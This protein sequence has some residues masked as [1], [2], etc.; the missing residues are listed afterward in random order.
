[1]LWVLAHGARGALAGALLAINGAIGAACFGVLVGTAQWL[2]LRRYLDGV[3]LWPVVTALSVPLGALL[4]LLLS[5]PLMFGNA[6]LPPLRQR[7][8]RGGPRRVSL[9]RDILVVPWEA[10]SWAPPNG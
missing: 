8:R 5:L 2:V 10:R 4:A 6:G 1:M 3:R 9:R 7:Q